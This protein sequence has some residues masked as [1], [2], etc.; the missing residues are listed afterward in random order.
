MRF[1][2]TVFFRFIS[3]EAKSFSNKTH[4]EMI[5]ALGEEKNKDILDSIYYARRIQT[6]LLPTEKY[7][8]G[9]LHE[10]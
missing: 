8:T 5:S 4:I 6:F 9:H 2:N 10:W 3:P 7:M 1:Y